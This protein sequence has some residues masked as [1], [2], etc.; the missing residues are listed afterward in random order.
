MLAFPTIS[1]YFM[2]SQ[3]LF[4]ILST[5]VAIVGAYLVYIEFLKNKI[6]IL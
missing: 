5:L 2:T 4:E 6:S 3:I 1:I